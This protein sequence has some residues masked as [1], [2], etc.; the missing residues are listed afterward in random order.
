MLSKGLAYE[1]MALKYLQNQKLTL[2]E[3]NF[4]TRLG[5]IDLIMKD[6]ETLTFIEVRY[7]K[8]TTHG[9]ASESVNLMKQEKLIKS[10]KI[11]LT[12]KNW[13]HLNSRF[14]VIAISPATLKPSQ[15][16]INWH[17]AAFTC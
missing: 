12:Q 15:H 1:N 10:A 9:S 7:R 5:E 17:K 6:G 8:S 4:R 11:F 2:I 3:K 14:D 13:W 16:E